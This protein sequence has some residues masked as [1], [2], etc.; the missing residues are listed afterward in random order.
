MNAPSHRGR[1]VVEAALVATSAR[2]RRPWADILRRLH[3]G[4]GHLHAEFRVALAWAV[5]HYLRQILPEI[6]GIY[7]VGSSLEEARRA[8]DVDI[9]LAVPHATEADRAALEALNA[10]VSEAY[11]GLLEDVPPHFRLLDLH[12]LVDSQPSL[13]RSMLRGSGTPRYQLG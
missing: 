12:L 13:F 9:L 1:L 11:A 4:D 10:E 2:E 8:S 6:G 5:Q 3:E 7:L